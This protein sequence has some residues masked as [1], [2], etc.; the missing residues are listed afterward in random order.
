MRTE[1]KSN[2]SFNKTLL[3]L[4][5]L[6]ILT[7]LFSILLG[8]F[9]VPVVTAFCAAVFVY[10]TGRKR[11]YSFVLP[12]ALVIINSVYFLL[13]GSLSMIWAILSIL[14]AFIIFLAY[15]S[16]RSKFDTSLILTGV[17]CAFVAL[18]ILL[19][20]MIFAR[21]LSFE[22]SIS[23]YY[24]LYT[25]L[26][27]GAAE[28][29]VDIY[30]ELNNTADIGAISLAD[31]ATMIDSSVGMLISVLVVFGFVIAGVSFKIFSAIISRC[32]ENRAY[33][34]TWR[35]LPPRI[36]GHFY[37]I[38]IFAYFFAAYNEG[39]FTAIIM[40]LYIIFMWMFAYVGFGEFVTKFMG[41]KRPIT[42]LIIFIVAIM[43]FSSFVLQILAMFGAITVTRQNSDTQTDPQN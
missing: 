38:L 15:K 20:G 7:G 31:A 26:R 1:L 13:L 21:E 3:I 37:Y 10:E 27:D 17:I 34:T 40:N 35:F 14:C 18:S 8:D 6:C 43:L 30:A 19:A 2:L 41:R 4:S 28:V 32:S 9:V 12:I 36:Y 5:A 11:V 23:F 39:V 42:V 24:D 29:I 22:A 25:V 33:I 16:N